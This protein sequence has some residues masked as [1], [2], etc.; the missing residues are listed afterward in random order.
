MAKFPGTQI[1]CD[2]KPVIIGQVVAESPSSIYSSIK[3]NCSIG[4]FSYIGKG[5]ELYNTHI[6]RFCS[7]APCVIIGPANHPTENLSTHLFTFSKNGPFKNS[8]EYQDWCRP[9]VRKPSAEK[10]ELILR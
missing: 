6:G 7:I 1:L 2:E 3:G 10:P 9:A 4:Y 5:S 8:K